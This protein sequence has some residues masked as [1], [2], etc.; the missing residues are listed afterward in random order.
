MNLMKVLLLYFLFIS[1]FT[2]TQIINDEKQQF[3]LTALDVIRSIALI[4][5]DDKLLPEVEEMINYKQKAIW[6]ENAYI[7]LW[8]MNFN[9]KTPYETGQSLLNELVEKEKVFDSKDE[10]ISLSSNKSRVK[11]KLPKSDLLCSLNTV[12]CFEKIQNNLKD[13]ELLLTENPQYSHRYLEFLR[14]K[15]FNEIAGNLMTA[16]VPNYRVLSLSQKFYHLSLMSELINND[17]YKIEGKLSLELTY[18]RNKLVQADTIFAKIIV[19]SMVNENI[20]LFSSLYQY[21]LIDIGLRKYQKLFSPLTKL[22]F[23]WH[24]VLY[25]EYSNQIKM[26]KYSSNSH[27]MINSDDH[28]KQNIQLMRLGLFILLKPNLTVNSLYKN[29]IKHSLKVSKLPAHQ[30]YESI[31]KIEV[32]SHDKIRNYLGTTMVDIA[33]PNYLSYQSLTF[34]LDM[35]IKLLR[36][37]GHYKSIDSILK[38]STVLSTYDLTKAFRKDNK[39]CYSGLIKQNKRY[40]CLIIIKK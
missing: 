5:T 38:K 19:A 10:I 32:G 7:Y 36:Q 9:T 6:E 21:K 24:H 15:Y 26:L 39:L 37:L 33:S 2:H 8:G 31:N 29:K 12:G 11:L 28:L 17:G 16:P 13:V 18:L 23:N 14:L 34:D 20:E 1:N 4:Y 22:E 30:F 35:K 3:I 27:F 25:T 40:Q